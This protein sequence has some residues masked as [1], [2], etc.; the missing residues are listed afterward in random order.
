MTKLKQALRLVV[1]YSCVKEKDT[2]YLP[3]QFYC[4]PLGEQVKFREDKSNLYCFWLALALTCMALVPPWRSV[5][6]YRWAGLRWRHNKVF[7]HLKEWR[8]CYDWCV[9]RYDLS[10]S[11]QRLFLFF[12]FGRWF[13]CDKYVLIDQS[14][15]LFHIRPDV[16]DPWFGVAA[17]GKEIDMAANLKCQFSRNRN[18]TN[19]SIKKYRAVNPEINQVEL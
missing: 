11:N 18:M 7:S 1:F 19:A 14:D 9:H 15:I 17:F 13:A 6:A 10:K 5:R 12:G 3:E 8:L 2:R 16:C 4:L